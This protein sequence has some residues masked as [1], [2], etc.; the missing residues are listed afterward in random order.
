MTQIAAESLGV[1]IADVTFRLGDS[2]L[3]DAPVERGSFTVSSVGSAVRAACDAVRKSLF[4]LARK[5][6]GSPL[7][8]ASLE[9]VEFAEGVVRLR[10]DRSRSVSLAQAMRHGGVA[11]IDEEVSAGPTS[12]QK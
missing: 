11:V 1:P 6:D 9:N 10:D 2:A 5:V 4:E 3:P 12:E 7:A 8:K